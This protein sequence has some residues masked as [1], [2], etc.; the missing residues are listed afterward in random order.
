MF[1]A[2]QSP[3]G[4]LEFKVA[5]GKD[6]FVF[7]EISTFPLDC[8]TAFSFVCA[9]YR[10][11]TKK[12]GTKGTADSV[13]FFIKLSRPKC[14]F[15]CGLCSNLNNS[16]DIAST[17]VFRFMYECSKKSCALFKPPS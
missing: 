8:R 16:L 11:G 4:T 12:V 3:N 6:I 7:A 10:I 1:I 15:L 9:G 2:L 13:S 14:I 17:K 5:N